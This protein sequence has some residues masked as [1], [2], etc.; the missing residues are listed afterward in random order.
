MKYC[1]IKYILAIALLLASACAWAGTLRTV[2]LK[3]DLVP[4]PDVDVNIILPE[5]YDSVARFPTVYLLHGYSGNYA[6]WSKIRP[7]L[8]DL[9][10]RYGMVMVMPDARTSWYWDSPVDSTMKME[11]FIINEL[12]PY[13]DSICPTIPVPEKRA[14]TGLSMGGHGAMWLAFR[15]P[16]VFKNVGSMSGGVDMML[17]PEGWDV[18]R[19]LGP[20]KGNEQLWSDH[21]VVSL[22]PTIQPGQFNII[23]D[24][25][26]DDFIVEGNNE[27]HKLLLEAEIPHDYISR[28]GVHDV[29]YWKNAVAYHLLFFNDAFNRA[30]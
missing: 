5:G 12:V 30:E 3:T 28:P 2:T 9:A 1:K 13:I 22:V 23:F 6:S 8:L 4:A 17:L 14:I 25:G 11:S 16:D 20:R 24:C 10:D 29:P 15:H 18:P 26:V 27:L 7:D 21:M 19:W